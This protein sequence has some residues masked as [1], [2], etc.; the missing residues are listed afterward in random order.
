MSFKD[1]LSNVVVRVINIK[2]GDV[3]E[4]HVTNYNRSTGREF[5]RR[6]SEWAMLNGYGVTLSN[7]KDEINA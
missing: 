2:T 6:T 7:E 5:I 4:E 3:Y 1:K